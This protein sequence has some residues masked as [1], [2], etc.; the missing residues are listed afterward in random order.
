[1]K[2][3]ALLFVL[4]FAIQT[5]VY[6]QSCLPDSIIFTTQTQIDSF[7]I[8]YPNCTTIEGN[9]R[10]IGRDLTNLNGLSVLTIIGGDFQLFCDSAALTN[11]TGLDALTFIGGDFHIGFWV[12]HPNYKFNR[13]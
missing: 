3:L 13:S 12:T 5:T 9:V 2:K 4:A 11:L 10:I 6:S 1:M 7:Q 8:N